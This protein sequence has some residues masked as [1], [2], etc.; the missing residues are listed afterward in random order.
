M[1]V[2]V[3]MPVYNAAS[4]VRE[5]IESILVQ[6][7][8]D[9][10]LIIINDGSKDETVR[11]VSEFRDSR[12]E[13]FQNETNRGVAATL[14]K[15]LSLA[16]G[17]Y[18]AR[19][20]ADDICVKTRL[21][22]QVDYL[23]NNPD[24]GIVGSWVR[25]FGDQLPLIEKTPVGS[26][27]LSAYL[28][29]DNPIFHPTVMYRRSLIDDGLAYD[30]QY[31]RTEDFELWTRAATFTRLNNIPLV[32][33]KMRH[34]DQSVTS[35]ATEVMTDQTCNILA[36]QLKKLGLSPTPDEV[37]FHHLVSRGKRLRS[38]EDVAQ[39]EQWLRLLRKKN[40][41]RGLHDLKSFDIVLG[42]I[43]FR[44]CKN[45]TPLGWWLWKRYRRFSVYKSYVPGMQDRLFCHVSIFWHLLV[46]FFNKFLPCAVK[47]DA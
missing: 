9:F 27:V 38:K 33:H 4:F 19:M 2:S 34:H 13:L 41:E 15:G 20:D 25:L 10:E 3:L 11:I 47:T 37:R 40:R 24:I 26:D 12:I 35:T 22:C 7:F 42:M 45:S 31:N 14:N 1:K 18:I 21:A 29:F 30:V 44:L 28:V 8:S 36:R 16:K 6:T 39:A 5:A 43:W 46:R 32:L 17:E 23:D